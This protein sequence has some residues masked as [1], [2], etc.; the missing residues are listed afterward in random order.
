MTD[1]RSR[2]DE[3]LVRYHLAFRLLQTCIGTFLKRK[4]EV[5]FKGNILSYEPVRRAQRKTQ[6]RLDGNNYLVGY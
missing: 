4:R 3:T 2:N 6:T 5:G 1:Q